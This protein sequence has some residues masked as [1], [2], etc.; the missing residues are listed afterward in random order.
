MKLTMIRVYLYYFVK[1][2]NNFKYIK[3]NENNILF[4]VHKM[5]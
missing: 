1:K 4:Q 5:S 3:N 2:L